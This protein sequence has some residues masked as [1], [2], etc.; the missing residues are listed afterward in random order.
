M[1]PVSPAETR[2]WIRRSRESQGLSPE[3][4]DKEIARIV[5]VVGSGTSKDGKAGAP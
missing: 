1:T 4:T 5:A 3:P 2:A